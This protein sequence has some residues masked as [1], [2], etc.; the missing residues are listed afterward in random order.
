MQNIVT[1]GFT[2]D[3]TGQKM[4]KSLGNV[5]DPFDIIKKIGTDGLR[6]WAGS[7]D[8]DGDIVVSDKVF[9]NIS[10][11]YRK[12]RN[13][14]RFALQNIVDFDFKKDAISVDKLY[15]L[16]LYALKKL[17]KLNLE[18]IKAYQTIKPTS[19]Y[20]AI[21]DLCA[22]FLSSIYFDI[23]KDIPVVIGDDLKYKQYIPILVM[24]PFI[25]FFISSNDLNSC[26]FI[27]ST[28]NFSLFKLTI[29]IHSIKCNLCNAVITCCNE[30]IVIK[31]Y[32]ISSILFI[33]FEYFIKDN[34]KSVISVTV[35]LGS[36]YS[37]NLSYASLE[38]K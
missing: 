37:L 9:E 4:S 7:V 18:C 26:Q 27:S 21:A 17:Y 30:G 10:E 19:V 34:M 24:E 31:S 15:P 33:V 32:I 35:I 28:F 6:L 25:F 38:Y 3:T 8:N 16:D 23:N 14:C 20:H 29:F 11:V 12:I 1:H 36:G 13:T 2:V 22:G 5:V